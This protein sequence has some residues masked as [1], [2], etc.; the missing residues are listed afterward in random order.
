MQS[1]RL[2]RGPDNLD[3][4]E[5]YAS[6]CFL[7]AL[8]RFLCRNGKVAAETGIQKQVARSN[9]P[10]IVHNGSSCANMKQ[11]HTPPIAFLSSYQRISV[12]FVR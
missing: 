3:C 2:A 5:A 9:V 12:W 8:A 6:V 7:D 11:A 4:K 1:V 10:Q